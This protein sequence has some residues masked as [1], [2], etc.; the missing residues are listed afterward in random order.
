MQS[1]LNRLLWPEFKRQ[2]LNRILKTSKIVYIQ[3]TSTDQYERRCCFS[4]EKITDSALKSVT[5]VLYS[6]MNMR[7]VLI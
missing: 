1:K 5:D 7:E 4:L 3:A 6:H 2:A